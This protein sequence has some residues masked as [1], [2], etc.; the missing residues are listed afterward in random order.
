MLLASLSFFA[1][2]SPTVWDHNMI[3]LAPAQALLAGLLVASLLSARS[4]RAVA[5]AA[6]VVVL[7][8]LAVLFVRRDE[9]GAEARLHAGVV[10]VQVRASGH[11]TWGTSRAWLDRRAD[12]VRRHTAP[13]EVIGCLDPWIAFA[14]GRVKFVRDWDLAGLAR[15]LQASLEA[16]GLVATLA[17]RRAPP[18]LGPGEIPVPVSH[19]PRA[20]GELAR[21]GPMADYLARLLANDLVWIRPDYLEALHAHAIALVLEPLPPGVIDDEDLLAAG[22]ERFTD[23]GLAAWRPA[24]R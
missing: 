12:F 8:A 24:R 5:R 3:D 22:Y 2:V 1:F 14:A 16:D 11:G 21:R 15:G 4:W 6:G 7:L 23:G 18:V 17:R 13:D 19:P 9:L 20:A 10:R